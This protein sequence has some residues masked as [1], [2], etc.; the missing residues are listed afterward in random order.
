M[1]LNS[2]S[3]ASE[4]AAAADGRF[5]GGLD[6]GIKSTLVLVMFSGGHLVTTGA[7]SSGDLTAFSLHSMFAGLGFAGVS[8]AMGDIS[9]ALASCDRYFSIRERARDAVH[10]M[11]GTRTALTSEV[12]KL[13]VEGVSFGYRASEKVLDNLSMTVE[14]GET[15]GICGESGSGK[16]TLASILLGLRKPSEGR[17]FYGDADIASFDSSMW[18]RRIVAYVRQE[19]VLFAESIRNNIRYACPTASNEAVEIAAKQAYCHDFISQLPQGYDTVLSLK[20]LALS[21]LS[22][23][24]SA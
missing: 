14:A 20:G 1:R 17:I 9:R 24:S 4:I 18:R 16:S 11:S 7:M 21:S 3:A 23:K 22:V 13:R 15:V 10:V 8:G 6:F 12:R 2:A 19:P 5:R